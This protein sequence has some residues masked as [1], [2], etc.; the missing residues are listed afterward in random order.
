M[1]RARHIHRPWS[2]THDRLLRI[3]EGHKNVRKKYIQEREEN[4]THGRENSPRDRGCYVKKRSTADQKLETPVQ[5][6]QRRQKVNSK[7]I[8]ADHREK[9]EE[10]RQRE[11]KYKAK[12]A[13][14]IK[15]FQNALQNANCNS[16][17][18]FI[19]SSFHFVSTIYLHSRKRRKKSGILSR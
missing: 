13:N 14:N 10:K 12:F 5:Q 2:S 16:M 11:E 4:N 18:L 3:F 7:Y 1:K 15:R 6:Q 19:S 9:K 8:S 17:R